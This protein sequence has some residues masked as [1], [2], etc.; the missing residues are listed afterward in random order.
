LSTATKK[1]PKENAAHTTCPAGT[2]ASNFA[3]ASAGSA[4]L[5]TSLTSLPWLVPLP[6]S[7]AEAGCKGGLKMLFYFMLA[8]EKNIRILRSLKCGAHWSRIY[9]LKGLRP[10]NRPRF[11]ISC[12]RIKKPR[13]NHLLL[14]SIVISYLK[15]RRI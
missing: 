6:K 10:L 12:W 13:C 8:H 5:L 3:Y 2:S 7:E 14:L 9:S 4:S 1:V 15:K 11:C